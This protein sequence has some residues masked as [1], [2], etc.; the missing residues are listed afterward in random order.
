MPA[1]PYSTT[2]TVTAVPPSLCLPV[3]EAAFPRQLHP[4]WPRLQERT[5]AWLLE[6]RLMSADKVAEYA[7]SLCYTDLMAGYYLGAPDAVL[8]AIA[9]YSAWF[10][11]WDDRHDR[12]IVHRRPAAWKRL[13]ERLH[14]ALDA[15]RDHLRHE[16]PLIAGF[17]DAMV[18]LY[19]FLPD[20]WNDRFARHFHAVI[21][22][23]DQE[24][25]NRTEGVIPTVDDYLELRRLTF[26]HAIWIDLLEP[27]AGCELP[28]T[29]RKHP[30]FQR[31]ALL[32][33]EF[34]A[35]YNDL[36]SLPKEIAG[37]EVHNLGISLIKHEELTLEEAVAELRRRIEQCIQEFLAAERGALRV[38]DE[39]DDGTVR[40]KE[41]ADAVRACVANMRNWFSSVY[42]FHHES[43]RY[44][45]DSW[46]DRST[47]PYV[48]NEAAGEK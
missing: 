31:A 43:G 46:D 21:D 2:S 25:H 33:Q 36:C 24:F 27:S 48:N 35:W 15:P 45:V 20:S 38:A 1:F 39:I 37:D 22:A 40:G 3:I 42:W 17:A 8:Q 13:R 7:D 34:A 11:V 9:D 30:E 10:F 32:S 18:R 26:A 14:T 12:D 23:Y 44:M 29:V 16:D 4:Y 6:M 41:I 28:D 47:P 5:R 19:S